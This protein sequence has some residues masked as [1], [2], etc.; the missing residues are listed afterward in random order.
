MEIFSII[1]YQLSIQ[2][3]KQLVTPRKLCHRIDNPREAGL[4]QVGRPLDSKSFVVTRV[5]V[6]GVLIGHE[7]ELLFELHN[8]SRVFPEEQPHRK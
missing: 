3:A 1:H 7:R 6:G 4:V 8:L 5:K 2:V